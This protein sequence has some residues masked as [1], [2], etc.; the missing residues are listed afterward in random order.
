MRVL[1]ALLRTAR[2]IASDGV[3]VDAARCV[4]RV[5]LRDD[6]SCLSGVDALVELCG[7]DAS[8]ARGV[9][10][11]RRD[12]V[13][14]LLRGVAFLQMSSPTIGSPASDERDGAL[15]RLAT[16]AAGVVR[17]HVALEVMSDDLNQ[18]TLAVCSVS[19]TARD[20]ELL[21]CCLKYF[22][23]FVAAGAPAPDA[24]ASVL[25]S[26]CRAV[27][28]DQFAGVSWDVTRALLSL[29]QHGHRGIRALC[30]LLRDPATSGSSHVRRGAVFCIGMACWGSRRVAALDVPPA[31]LL[32][33][34]IAVLDDDAGASPIVAHEIALAARRLVRKFG[35]TL[36]LEWDLVLEL[37]LRLAPYVEPSKDSA[38]FAAVLQ[39]LLSTLEQMQAAGQY[40][41][42]PQ[43]WA[44]VSARYLALPGG[45]RAALRLRPEESPPPPRSLSRLAL[46]GGTGEQPLSPSTSTGRVAA[47]TVTAAGQ[48]AG[49]LDAAVRSLS[50]GS[51][52]WPVALQRVVAECWR[53]QSSATRLEAIDV[54]ERLFAVH[55]YLFEVEL[56][57]KLVLPLLEHG[58]HDTDLEVSARVFR[59][60]VP[61]L[62]EL[63][64]NRFLDAVVL[65]RGGATA[66]KL[67]TAEQ[68]TA[69]LGALLTNKFTR[70]PAAHTRAVFEALCS[71]AIRAPQL[72][73]RRVALGHLSQIN[74]NERFRIRLGQAVSPYLRCHVEQAATPPPQHFGAA[75]AEPL[76]TEALMD[77][78]LAR[79]QTNEF[80]DN[81]DLIELS[82]NGLIGALQNCYLALA[83]DVGRATA[84]VCD[85]LYPTSHK[86][87]TDPQ[88][89]FTAIR[90]L[91]HLVPHRHEQRARLCEALMRGV[92]V[93][94]TTVLRVKCV[95]GVS[96]SL[97]ELPAACFRHGLSSLVAALAAIPRTTETFL[98]TLSFCDV[99][100]SVRDVRDMLTPAEFDDILRFVLHF[101][102]PN[103]SNVATLAFEI[104][105]RWVLAVPVRERASRCAFVV[106]AIE[107]LSQRGC[108]LAEAHHEL[109]ARY[110]YSDARPGLYP[111]PFRSALVGDVDGES[112]DFAKHWLFGNA[113]MTVRIGAAGF[114]HV[115]RRCP[116]GAD[117]Y[118]LQHLPGVGMHRVSIPFAPSLRFAP[119]TTTAVAVAAA[120]HAEPAWFIAPEALLGEPLTS[121]P[122]IE[123]LP[124]P[125]PQPQ[126]VLPAM[127]ELPLQQ[128]SLPY[129]LMSVQS[130]VTAPTQ[131][132]VAVAERAH[133]INILPS[134]DDGEDDDEILVP[135]PAPASTAAAAAAAAA[136]A[137]AAPS[138]TASPPPRQTSQQD[139]FL[140]TLMHPAMAILRQY[141]F[142]H[143][144]P[145]E[146]ESGAAVSR[147]LGVLDRTL[148]VTT[149]KVGIV[150]VGAGQ[151]DLASALRNRAGSSRYNQLLHQLGHFERLVDGEPTRHRYTGGLDRSGSDGEHALFW[152]DR[153][154]LIV[155]H[156]CTLMPNRDGDPAC[157]SKLR[158][159]GNDYV[160]IVFSAND[161][162]FDAT[163]FRGQFNFVTIIIY[164]K[165]LG[166]Y[167]ID[168]VQRSLLMRFGPITNTLVVTKHALVGMLRATIIAADEAA[169]ERV[170]GHR[171]RQAN[172]EVRL[173]QI[174]SLIDK[175]KR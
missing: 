91:R 3:V 34:L 175:R 67:S 132:S 97:L 69:T 49:D 144:Q 52:A 121:A 20:A 47:A 51:P 45:V 146:L 96:Q 14:L 11:L 104:L 28:M 114:V 117:S 147:A 12:L 4:K 77:A 92:A 118:V 19:D 131:E 108:L 98:S 152:S 46:S 88:N 101:C 170:D 143:E 127:Q 168:I 26:L 164:P 5:L 124:Q 9:A 109:F 120:P 172:A 41:G 136:V 48:P 68:C 50:P 63:L 173:M 53:S 85:W 150:Y 137:V 166:M 57:D 18:L 73:P 167:K 145:I 140:T 94:P 169:A 155:Y 157:T 43:R 84:A 71:V 29:P 107:A 33:S 76:A 62:S 148:C 31:V 59:F 56:V 126:A 134:Y 75:A 156:V 129:R 111:T 44:M 171:R 86:P 112:H 135:V 138:T 116:A 6:A 25:A 153:L 64:S 159:I 40:I 102:D 130:D 154:S 119:R 65:L 78:Y 39:D 30:A 2:L 61:V 95:D 158:H 22:D 21:D 142:L 70:P 80:G 13:P 54:F 163:Q 58:I 106:E 115:Q 81:S 7:G 55:K 122:A 123:A 15:R 42:S 160:N 103:K 89:W 87:S 74:A 17:R 36:A 27:N 1:A 82:L 110:L 128:R 16:L 10:A 149:R 35:E 66:A 79:L 174:K 8:D 38:A 151:R 23:A 125:Q 60:V 165:R 133:T 161:E 139:D 90:A 83:F 113:V 105:G 24:V 141:P 99:L 37:M 32:P 93:A 162:P 72:T 100:V